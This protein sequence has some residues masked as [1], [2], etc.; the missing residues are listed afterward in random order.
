MQALLRLSKRAKLLPVLFKLRNV[1]IRDVVIETPTVDI[2][3][4]SHEGRE[5]CLKKYRVRRQSQSSALREDLVEVCSI[6]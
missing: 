5:V 6:Q 1:E 4:G 3:R 2:F